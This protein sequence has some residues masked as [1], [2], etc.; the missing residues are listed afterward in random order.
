MKKTQE[1]FG[2]LFEQATYNLRP[3]AMFVTM[4]PR[5]DRTT[6]SGLIIQTQDKTLE[7]YRAD[8]PVWVEVIKVGSDEG[9]FKVG[10][11]LLTPPLAVVNW[12]KD[13][14]GAVCNVEAGRTLGIMENHEDNAYL[15]FED[16]AAYEKA[17]ELVR[18][19][20]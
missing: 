9:A 3:D 19:N 14:L 16:K 4:L 2:P 11:I 5:E 20:S 6:K 7:G 18:E 13:F 15:V 10:N 1:T 8:V 12:Y 17:V